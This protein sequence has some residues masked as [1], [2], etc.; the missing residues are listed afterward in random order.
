M[1]KFISKSSILI[2][3]LLFSLN[4]FSQSNERKLIISGKNSVVINNGDIIKVVTKDG[5]IT[6]GAVSLP[7]DNSININGSEIAITN[8]SKIRVK[9][10]GVNIPLG[11]VITIIG[12]GGTAFGIT[13]IAIGV[14]LTNENSFGGAIIGFLF[15]GAGAIITTTGS[16]ITITGIAILSSGKNYNLNSRYSKIEIVQ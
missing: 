10:Q 4:A 2:I 6:K 12:A 5:F 8:I 1:K 16:I 9:Q 13:L 3:I 11:T 14:S 15:Y 7:N